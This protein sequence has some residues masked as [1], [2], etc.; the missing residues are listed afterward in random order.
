[1]VNSYPAENRRFSGRTSVSGGG[2]T[3]GGALSDDEL[4]FRF[5]WL[6]DDIHQKAVAEFKDDE[7][8]IRGDFT[9]NLIPSGWQDDGLEAVDMQTAYNAVENA[10]DHILTTPKT[11]V[12]VPVMEDS[13]EAARDAA[14]NRRLFHDM[15][16]Q[17][18]KV[19]DG[20][21][22]KRGKKSLV[23]GKLVLKKEIRW[24]LLPD[25]E[26]DA[27]RN[28]KRR[29]R[30]QLKRLAQS[31]FLWR[32]RLVPKETV[33][34]DPDKPWDPDYVY[35][36]FKIRVIE[37]KSRWP[38]IDLSDFNDDEEVEYI[39][40]WSKPRGSQPG[41]FVQWINDERVHASDN[42]Y[43]WE[44]RGNW[45]GYVPYAI[46]DPGWGDVDADASPE[47]RYYS[48]VR[49]LRS[50]VKAEAR[51]LTAVDSWLRMYAW[52]IVATRNM[53]DADDG[54]KAIELGPGARVDLSEDQE[55]GL[56]NF[57][58]S[59][60]SIFQFLDRV[61]NAANQSSKFGA[62]SGA[63]Q[64]GVD[65]ASEAAQLEANA[66]TKLSGPIETLQRLAARINSWVSMDIQ[67][68]L[69][70]PITISGAVEG[71]SS[72]VTIKPTDIAGRYHTLVEFG[73]TDQAMEEL[74]R[75]RIWGDAI[76]IFPGLSQRTAMEKAGIPNP[77]HQMDERF[78]EDLVNSDPARQLAITLMLSAFGDAGQQI[79]AGLQPQ[80]QGGPNSANLATGAG[81]VDNGEALRRQAAA[82]AQQL[83]PERN[84]G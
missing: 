27:D 71:D 24:E 4:L 28:A 48:I 64:R 11:F 53:P 38:D 15:W 84:F 12:P 60:V 8:Y 57:G 36:A 6:K 52:P 59:P 83:Q 21:P 19:E 82:Q 29:F 25:L 46:G 61:Q 77:T 37:A 40:Y 16:W 14:E 58:E 49:P 81:A 55:M 39:E 80:Q 7:S 20:D 70:V 22:L 74:R 56:V 18:V 9:A 13:Q 47:D 3:S 78:I 17:R 65:T 32:L 1:M 68:I 67:H 63:P 5:R 10:S 26:E 42:P 73:T 62:L 35:E 34:E 33:F 30:E 31:T 2:S 72:E 76:Q 23:K 66:T 44:D 43:S 69:R 50:L 79:L 41:E 54:E 51:Q 75:L 45:Y